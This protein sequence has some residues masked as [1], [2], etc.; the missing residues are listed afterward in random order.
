VLSDAF[1]RLC[2]APEYH[3]LGEYRLPGI[4]RPVEVFTVFEPA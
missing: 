1:A 2:A 3:R 4:A